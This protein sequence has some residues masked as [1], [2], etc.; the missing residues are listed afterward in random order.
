ME[1]YTVKDLIDMLSK[2]PLDSV[3]A[4]KYRDT[5]GGYDGCDFDVS[6][7]LNTNDNTVEKGVVLL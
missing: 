1:C 2:F 4:V 3:V 7:Y 5:G 6:P